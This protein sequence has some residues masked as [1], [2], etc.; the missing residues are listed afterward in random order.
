MKISWRLLS[1]TLSLRPFET[2]L[3]PRLVVTSSI[4]WKSFFQTSVSIV[5]GL[6]SYAPVAFLSLPVDQATNCFSA[7]YRSFSLR[8]W[9]VNSPETDARDEYVDFLYCLRKKYSGMKDTPEVFT[10]MVAFLRGMPELKMRKHL[11]YIFQLSCL[12]LTSKLPELPAIK[13]PVVDCSD[14]RSRLFDV[15]MPARSYLANVADSGRVYHWSFSG[16]F[17]RSWSTIQRW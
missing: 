10:D 13:L 2:T 8:G 6:G 1:W 11:F 5:R 9:L 7:L 4:S 12:C 15:T 17:Q 3:P 14:P 16:Y